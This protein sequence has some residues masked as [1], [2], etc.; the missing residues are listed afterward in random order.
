MVPIDP[1]LRED[2]LLI[3]GHP[4]Q[5]L[6]GIGHFGHLGGHFLRRGANLDGG[7]LA[8]LIGRLERAHRFLYSTRE[9][10]DLLHR[11]VNDLHAPF[12]FPRQ[13]AY[14]PQALLGELRVRG[15]LSRLVEAP[16]R[17][18][19]RGSDS[20]LDERYQARDLARR[21]VGLVGELADLRRDHGEA[22]AQD[23]PPSRPE[24]T[25]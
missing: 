21:V 7:V 25:R 11:R 12:V 22:L 16:G 9:T 20:T 1:E 19:A 18:F 8:A 3:L 23:R 13:H 6:G 2:H 24:W 15:V 17:G 4:G 5:G 14:V 10:R